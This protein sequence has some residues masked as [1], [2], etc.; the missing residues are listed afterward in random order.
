MNYLIVGASSGLGRD[1]AYTLSE[2]LHDL[3]LISRD[4]RDLDAMKSD[5]EYKY[6]I[7]INSYAVDLASKDSII[8][9]LND[10]EIELSTIVKS[11]KEIL[12]SDVFLP[13]KNCFLFKNKLR[14]FS[15]C[16]NSI[17]SFSIFSENPRIPLEDKINNLSL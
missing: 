10:N 15:T 16:L 6:K 11:L 7:K 13:F 8:S 9:F 5:L 2:N 3:D 12:D 1:L 17:F 14:L 4:K